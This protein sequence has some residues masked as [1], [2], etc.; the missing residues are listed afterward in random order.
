MSLNRPPVYFCA[1]SALCALLFWNS[2]HSQAYAVRKPNR[3]KNSPSPDGSRKQPAKLAHPV[4]HK[5]RATAH[6]HGD[7]VCAS[8]CAASRHPTPLLKQFEFKRLIDQLK[9]DERELA[10]DSLL[11]YGP[12]TLRRLQL[13][14]ELKLSGDDRQM[15][16]RELRR[17]K[18]NVEFRLVAKDGSSLANLPSTKVPFDLRH[19]FELDEFNIPNLIASGTVKRVGRKHLWA[20]L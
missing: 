9:S 18:V 13:S 20:R 4:S 16:E 15:L 3:P 1:L 17:Q 11:F 5:S 6:P 8:G 19:E 2:T 10:I 12:Q 7:K 14:P